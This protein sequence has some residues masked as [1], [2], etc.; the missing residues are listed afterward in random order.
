MRWYSKLKDVDFLWSDEVFARL[1]M[2]WTQPAFLPASGYVIPFCR[3]PATISV[4]EQRFPYKG[5]FFSGKGARTRLHR[6]PFGSEAILCQIQ[7][8]KHFAFYP[9][10][11]DRYVRSGTVFC[12]PLAPDR[13]MFPE[14]AKARPAFEDVLAPGEIVF[15]PDGWFHDVTSLDDSISI[16]WNFVHS[17]RA[18]PFARIL[19]ESPKDRE[20]DVVRFFL[21]GRL[22]PEAGVGDILSSVGLAGT[23][24]QAGMEGVR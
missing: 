11:D 23:A 6:D 2:D 5:L 12:D 3:P 10:E 19:A 22:S 7:G 24:P 14:F 15:I 1:S 8:R 21:D 18:Q 4:T 16:T 20:V 13:D 9:P 17:A